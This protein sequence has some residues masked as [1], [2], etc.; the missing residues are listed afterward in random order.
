MRFLKKLCLIDI[1]LEIIYKYDILYIT[2]K[3]NN[4]KLISPHLHCILYVY[5]LIL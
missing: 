5:L 4:V 2:R 1:N 3:T